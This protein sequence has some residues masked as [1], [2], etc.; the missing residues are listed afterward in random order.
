MRCA[1]PTIKYRSISLD[2][3]KLTNIIAI[4]VGMGEGLGA[5]DN[6]RSALITLGL[7]EVTRLAA[8]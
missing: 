6:T 5:G 4:A 8:G 2:Y 1:T 3:A 7:A